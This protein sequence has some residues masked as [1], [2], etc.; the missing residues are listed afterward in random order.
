MKK[1][2]VDGQEGTT[3]LRIVERLEKREDVEILRIGEARRKELRE[4]KSLIEKSDI[5]FLCLP[6]EQAARSVSV[7]ENPDTKIIDASTAHRTNPDWAY[8]FPE[9][10]PKH[11]QKIVNS[12]RVAVPGCY[13][14]GFV[15]LV[16]PLIAANV[17]ECH[18]PVFSYGISGYS[19]G[20]KTR[21]NQ[22]ESPEK[23]YDFYS[24]M[25]YSLDLTHKHLP[26]MKMYSGLAFPPMFSPIIDDYYN[27]MLV[28]IPLQARVM[29]KRT[30]I[31]ELKN[32]Y[33][34]HYQ[35][36][37]FIHILDDVAPDKTFPH[38]AANPLADTNALEIA[39]FGNSE[40][41]MLVSRLDNL[42][43]GASGA[44]V[45]CMN[46]MCNLPEETAI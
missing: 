17:L 26:E 34:R 25:I 16:Y 24:P 43:K 31:D 35:N 36:Q 30:S 46:I 33:K 21:I 1:V 7:C 23:P 19:G 32:V 9:L 22:Y 41:F 18:Y 45:Q 2:F 11:R 40:Q 15:S 42:G 44:A 27:G 4:R 14:T 39:V 29:R 37:Q 38:F 28:C 10:S 6:D 20:G 8:G 13:A 3:G 5:T 12:K